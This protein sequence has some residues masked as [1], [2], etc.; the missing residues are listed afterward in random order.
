[1]VE[2][3]MSYTFIYK[4]NVITLLNQMHKSE[5]IL[6]PKAL[7]SYKRHAEPLIKEEIELNENYQ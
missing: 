6:T 3:T 7:E 5:A 1:M 2:K 4:P